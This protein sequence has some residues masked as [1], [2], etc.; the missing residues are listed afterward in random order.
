VAI[1]KKKKKEAEKAWSEMTTSER[2]TIICEY[3]RYDLA[4]MEEL[5][6]L[7]PGTISRIQNGR[8][9]GDLE[10]LESIARA[11]D[12]SIEALRG[13]RRAWIDFPKVL[14]LESLEAFLDAQ[15]G[16]LLDGVE[17]RLRGIAELPT[18]PKTKVQWEEFVANMTFWTDFQGTSP[19]KSKIR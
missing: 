13:T 9:N 7:P 4:K 5:T 1:Q 15:K 16:E 19:T 18:A 8:R 11:L 14:A 12:V 10:T 6:S 3:W 17:T 2:I